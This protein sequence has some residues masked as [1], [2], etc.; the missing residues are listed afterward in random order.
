MLGHF[1]RAQENDG[2]I[3][4]VAGAQ[5]RVGVNIDFA[6]ACAHASEQRSD[7]CLGFLAQMATRARIE[8]YIERAR[9]GENGILGAGCT[10][11]GHGVFIPQERGGLLVRTG[12]AWYT[13]TRNKG[14]GPWRMCW[15]WWM[16]YF[17]RPR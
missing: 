15:R 16:I 5:D 7:L 12:P 14:G 11:V 8:S 6:Q 3:Q 17:F 10:V 2:H 1:A 13:G 4:I 9:G